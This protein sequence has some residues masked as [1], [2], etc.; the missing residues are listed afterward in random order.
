MTKKNKSSYPE[1]TPFH[2][3][4]A[5]QKLDSKNNLIYEILHLAMRC[6]NPSDTTVKFQKRDLKL[7]LLKDEQFLEKKIN[8]IN[9]SQISS[10]IYKEIIKRKIDWDTEEE[11]RKKG[12]HTH[13]RFFL[14][15][16]NNTLKFLSFREDQ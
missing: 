14:S 16:V 4:T 1:V 12:I 8:E 3:E 9:Y 10:K 5:V 7:N 11:F 2:F 6:I 13:Y 15:F